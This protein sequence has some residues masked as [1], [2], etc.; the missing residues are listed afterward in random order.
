MGSLI[1]LLMA[2]GFAAA[3]W[4]YLQLSRNLSP[5]QAAVEF[6]FK[7]LLP[8][9]TAHAL[10]MTAVYF[11]FKKNMRAVL[12]FWG[13]SFLCLLAVSGWARGS[14]LLALIGLAVLLV[15]AGFSI[16]NKLFY[17]PTINWGICLALGISMSS[18]LCSY[19]A[20]I[21]W[22]SFGV[23]G[24]LLL[25]PLI[26]LFFFRQWKKT[27]LEWIRMEWEHFSLCWSYP[28]AM[29][30]EGFFLVLVYLIVASSTPEG[31][32]DAIRFYWPYLK[33][34][35]HFHGFFDL[36]YQWS[37]VIPQA[38][39]A[40]AS[41]FYLTL[42]EQGVRWAMMLAWIAL[43]ASVAFQIRKNSA[44]GESA[45]A[46]VTALTMIMASCPLVLTVTSSLMQDNFVCLMAVLLGVITLEGRVDRAWIF[47]I[48]WGAFL[49][50]CWCSKYTL[51][52]YAAP[53]GL[54]ALC[55]SWKNNG[56]ARTLAGMGL[57][58]VSSLMVA[59]PWLWRSYH[60][61][62]NPVFPFFK[63]YFSSAI[64]P[65]FAGTANLSNFKFAQGWQK[66]VLWPFD[67]T[68]H[69]N[70]YNEGYP[71]TI[72]LTLLV[73]L[74][75]SLPIL[76]RGNW[77]NRLLLLV[78]VTGTLLLWQVTPYMR[79]WLPGLWLFTL[80]VSQGTAHWMSRRSWQLGLSLAAVII[81]LIHPLFSMAVRWGDTKGWPW[82]YYSNRISEVDYLDRV[83]P[84]TGQLRQKG[85]KSAGYPRVWFTGYE[86]VGHL[87]V[88][89]LDSTIWEMEYH[90]AQGLRSR[91][92]YLG[93]TDCAYW[94]IDINAEHIRW[95][96]A[97]GLARYFWTDENLIATAGPVRVFRM[98][99]SEKILNS[100]E[101]SRVPGTDLLID[102]GFEKGDLG[103]LRFWMNYGEPLWLDSPVGAKEG[104]K[105]TVV[106]RTTCWY[107]TVPVPRQVSEMVLSFWIRKTGKD[108]NAVAVPKLQWLNEKG[109]TL[110][111]ASQPFEAGENWTECHFSAPVPRGSDS[112][113]L[114]L[115]VRNSSEPCGYDEVHLRVKE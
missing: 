65:N 43:S 94:F 51:I 52:A 38:G 55:R 85:W 41:A 45:S 107:Q 14:S 15:V 104:C 77:R 106:N 16:A 71:G 17:V 88:M 44:C 37:Y 22:L 42:G 25:L 79:Y 110:S 90:G 47:W 27:F 74:A 72:G 36:P 57:G 5:R 82:N 109:E 96:R 49:G 101:S 63:T 100:I 102:G 95:Y 64:W 19:L 59:A 83:F 28:Q 113:M 58:G 115:S 46:P 39:L 84:G 66:W 81:S 98:A 108:K 89:P 2:A 33:S 9:M 26:F 56:L 67:M 69:S 48:S 31:S 13:I 8:A 103:T 87:D 21:H 70:H 10:L 24:L 75:F 18:F 97:L 111:E 23:I 12:L 50:L 1:G 54:I 114:Y 29:A 32:S 92:R 20:W 91:I 30:L 7:T 34:L 68:Y 62:G 60:Q 3:F 61:S 4:Y 99:S 73:L 11:L 86:G 35:K 93:S 105:Y 112:A 40:Y 53:L 80:A 78:A 76:V 6:F